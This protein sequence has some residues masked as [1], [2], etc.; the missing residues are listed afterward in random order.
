MGIEFTP[1]QKEAIALRGE[2]IL[3]SAGAGSGKTALLTERIAG[4]VLG[5]ETEVDRLL[6]VTFTKAAA[7][8]MRDRIRSRLYEGARNPS[9]LSGR[10]LQ[11]QIGKLDAAQIST[12]DAF[13]YKIARE[14]F[15]LTDL[16]PG[17]R[18]GDESEVALLRTEAIE[19]A[20]EEVYASDDEK[21]KAL[22]D[23]YSSYRND[24]GLQELIVQVMRF[25]ET[26][27]DENR[28]IG[29]SL[30]ALEEEPVGARPVYRMLGEEIKAQAV[31][32]AEEMD[33]AI[34]LF[35]ENTSAPVSE[36]LLD[37]ALYYRSFDR[38][39]GLEDILENI[40]T[41]AGYKR[42]S[43]PRKKTEKLPEEAASQIKNIRDTN[44]KL[45]TE[46]AA[47]KE[48]MGKEGTRS[49]EMSE[50]LQKLMQVVSD[51]S[52]RFE[53]KKREAG[54][55][56]FA[57]V[58]KAVIRIL[59]NETAAREI[60][61]RFDY[62]FFDE[63]QDTNGV[64]EHIIERIASPGGRFMV[65]DLKQSIY[66]FRKADPDI[67]IEKYED[68]GQE[69]GGKLIHLNRNF[70]STTQVIDGINALFGKIMSK[71]VGDLDY[72]KN[73]A[74]L[75]G[76]EDYHG[77]KPEMVLIDQDDFAEQ[78]TVELEAE[79]AAGIISE[80]LERRPDLNLSD[81]AI[82]HR[83]A[84]AVSK[85][86]VESLNKRG[87]PV[88][89]E[90]TGKFF[91]SIEV[92]T[93]I[94]LLSLIDNMKQDI[95]L[96]TVMHSV[97]GGFTLQ[98]EAEIRIASDRKDRSLK[99]YESL[100]AYEEE[101]E[102]RALREKVH[103][104][105]E[106]IRGWREEARLMPMDAFI[107]KVV[108]ES[109][110]YYYAGALEDG[111]IRQGNIRTLLKKAET[112]EKTAYKGI[113][114]FLA[115]LSRLRR[116]N[117]PI[118]GGESA[119]EEN[120]VHLISIHKSKGLEFKVVILTGAGKRFNLQDTAKKL[121]L[122]KDYGFGTDYHYL[123]RELPGK[124]RMV[125]K[126]QF[127]KIM[128]S[129]ARSEEMRLLYVALTRAEEELYVIGKVKDIEKTARKNERSRPDQAAT[130]LDWMIPALC[131]VE[132]DLEDFSKVD[133]WRVVR[134]GRHEERAESLEEA[135]VV[136][137]A[138]EAVRDAVARA[139]EKRLEEK[140][141]ILPV[142]TKISVSEL[143]NKKDEQT[144]EQEKMEPA[145]PLRPAPA[146]ERGP[147]A[148][149]QQGTLVHVMM[150]K[151]DFGPFGALERT[152]EQGYLHEIER[153]V[154][155]TAHRE[156]LTQ[157]EVDAVD[158]RMILSFLHSKTGQAVIRAYRE[159]PD[160]VLREYSMLLSVPA[161]EID[162]EA[163][164]RREERVKIQG[165]IDLC[166]YDGEAWTVVDYK[167]DRMREIPPY[168]RQ[169]RLR[170][171]QKQVSAYTKAV[172]ALTGEA[173]REPHIFFLRDGEDVVVEP[174]ALSGEMPLL[175]APLLEEAA[176]EA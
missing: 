9:A 3:V 158:P 50:L 107:W 68:Y 154:K 95:P 103:A 59:E 125:L 104:F 161:R 165:I 122:H 65:G 10:A 89:S 152:D 82:L 58:A 174:S 66:R 136:E 23:I 87:I 155:E 133:A 93:L 164:A 138:P 40:R 31:R 51:A 166:Y 6:V 72:D 21:M 121:L 119:E 148:G 85:Q 36:H 137:E 147:V 173:V 46:Y 80:V 149:A 2:N 28:W 35:E 170:R 169:D 34:S 128:A 146:E 30:L 157:E 100:L 120:A 97:I 44:K 145:K 52:S 39:E 130:Y 144:G 108:R 116:K 71:E 111:K 98:E 105:L 62:I 115:Y 42:A 96:Y 156:R 172:Q 63:Y 16:P 55:A 8:E 114:H 153:Q 14:Y 91:D 15:Q 78:D 110:Y 4:L 13:C 79:Q 134:A 175:S 29:E 99:F 143:K 77:V 113:S 131:G 129:E 73:A 43:Y 61:G 124:S 38:L 160:F 81:I 18:I 48:M 132:G 140:E 54:I 162:P 168:M 86:M 171:Y 159:N 24:A 141:R 112:Y 5:G 75:A 167:T 102:N 135:Q 11:K 101:G 106:K 27:P 88:I 150:E 163:Y 60:R 53:E 76:R 26:V 69:E 90:T 33:E 49:R 57:Q 7:A 70:R 74:F 109:G 17:F 22:S 37:D 118:T 20:L 64:Q 126:K 1:E 25:L 83:S 84:N 176:Q 56:D 127:A 117:Q 151:L 19:E 92:Q 142:P 32:A 67:F 139:F 12:M 123:T 47:L 45:F 94:S 41:S